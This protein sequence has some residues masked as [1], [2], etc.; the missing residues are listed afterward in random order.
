MLAPRQ[1]V[2][3]VRPGAGARQ[4]TLARLH[5]GHPPEQ[6]HFGLNGPLGQSGA[7]G[8]SSWLCDGPN[9][10]ATGPSP[11]AQQQDECSQKAGSPVLQ[12]AG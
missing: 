3:R 11:F 6:G 2:E 12:P 8:S 4:G 10:G 1:G 5:R 9:V 7:H